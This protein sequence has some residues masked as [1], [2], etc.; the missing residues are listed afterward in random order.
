MAHGMMEQTTN[1]DKVDVITL[2]DKDGNP[3]ENGT[4]STKIPEV[5]SKP[6]QGYTYGYWNRNIPSEVTKNDDG[7]E[8]VYSYEIVKTIEADIAEGKGK[9][10]NPKTYDVMNRYLLAGVGGIFVLTLVSKIRRKY[11]RKAKKI[12]F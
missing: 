9:S 7:K 6:N 10:P 3:S 11:S 5:G 2:Y 4:G 12:Q 8:Y 1:K